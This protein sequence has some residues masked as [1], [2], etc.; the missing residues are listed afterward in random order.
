MFFQSMQNRTNNFSG[1]HEVKRFM[2]GKLTT[3]HDQISGLEKRFDQMAFQNQLAAKT[4]RPGQLLTWINAIS[5]TE[6]YDRARCDRLESTCDGILE[7]EEF[8]TWIAPE[9]VPEAVKIL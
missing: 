8:Q 4:E 1:L 7:R 3:L 9:R 5:T 2:E 6:D